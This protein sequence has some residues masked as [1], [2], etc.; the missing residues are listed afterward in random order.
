[1]WCR[2]HRSE[3]GTPSTRCALTIA[4]FCCGVK[5]LRSREFDPFWA[6]SMKSSFAWR[7][8]NARKGKFQFRLRQDSRMVGGAVRVPSLSIANKLAVAGKRRTLRADFHLPE[9]DDSTNTYWR[10]TPRCFS[11]ASKTSLSFSALPA[12][13]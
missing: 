7:Y 11:Q 9:R 1:M 10:V 5:C 2:S 6:R 3:I 13:M 8:A 12:M 4:T